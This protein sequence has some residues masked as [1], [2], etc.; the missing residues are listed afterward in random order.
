MFVLSQA[1][2][3]VGFYDIHT[4]DLLS[5]MNENTWS[6]MISQ[7]MRRQISTVKAS[8]IN[9]GFEDSDEDENFN[10]STT[11]TG[12]DAESY[13]LAS[14]GAR[15]RRNHAIKTSNL[16]EGENANVM[17]SPLTNGHIGN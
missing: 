8:G 5:Y 11:L 3:V 12:H 14:N 13:E 6:P 15:S 4:C 16:D 7:I 1:S 10:M 17:L 9:A 2:G